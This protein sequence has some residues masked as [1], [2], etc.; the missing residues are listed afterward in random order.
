MLI[1]FSLLHISKTGQNSLTPNLKSKIFKFILKILI[2]FKLR[3]T[4]NI[5]AEAPQENEKSWLLIKRR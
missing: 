2:Y 4:F 5:A 1:F 3:V